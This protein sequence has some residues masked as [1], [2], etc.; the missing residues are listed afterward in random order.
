MH[1]HALFRVREYG[2][3]L[4]EG[5]RYAAAHAYCPYYIRSPP[6]SPDQPLHPESVPSAGPDRSGGHLVLPPF[7][8]KPES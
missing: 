1:C 4:N 5:Y 7:Y 8:T 3:L 2:W 6:F